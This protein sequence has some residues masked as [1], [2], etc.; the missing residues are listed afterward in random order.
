MNCN[1]WVLSRQDGIA[2]KVTR[3]NFSDRRERKKKKKICICIYVGRTSSNASDLSLVGACL[4]LPTH[5][6]HNGDSDDASLVYACT[7]RR[8]FFLVK[9]PRTDTYIWMI[10]SSAG[11]EVDTGEREP[12]AGILHEVDVHRD[13][14]GSIIAEYS[15]DIGL[16]CLSV[17]LHV[18]LG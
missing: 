17:C 12:S 10:H 16:V 15:I 6:A 13:V 4:S 7:C 9:H 11:R 8:R 2:K 1:E 18:R 3:V 5:P 14:L